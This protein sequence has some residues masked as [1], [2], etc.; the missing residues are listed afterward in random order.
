MDL[1]AL[2]RE[3]VNEHNL[4]P[5][6]KGDLPAPTHIRQGVNPTCGDDINLQLEVDEN[7]VIT[8]ASFN[9]S[10]C[11]ISQASADIMIDLIEGKTKEEALALA[12]AFLAMVR[13]TATDEQRELLDEAAALEDVA[14]M[15]ARAKCATLGWHTLEKVLREEGEE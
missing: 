7:G 12:D 11:A 14:H 13:G 9:G 4:H 15:P 5:G 10:G 3:I 6:H 1:K 8:A 2:Y